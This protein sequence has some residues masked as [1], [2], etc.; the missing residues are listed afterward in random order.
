MSFFHLF[1]STPYIYDGF[2]IRLS[3]GIQLQ[4]KMNNPHSIQLSFHKSK[5]D[6][7]HRV[8]AVEKTIKHPI[9]RESVDKN[10]IRKIVFLSADLNP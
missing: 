6:K 10:Q 8:K 7:K 1:L 9:L 2:N 4:L 3:D 5:C